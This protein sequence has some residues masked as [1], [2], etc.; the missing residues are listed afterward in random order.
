V[1]A[2]IWHDKSK[3]A[4]LVVLVQVAEGVNRENINN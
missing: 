1:C 4:G 2:E 3:N